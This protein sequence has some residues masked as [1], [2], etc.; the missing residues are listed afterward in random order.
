[1]SC[2]WQTLWLT[3]N[4]LILNVELGPTLHKHTFVIVILVLKQCLTKAISINTKGQYY[5]KLQTYFKNVPSKLE[6][7][8]LSGH[9]DNTYKD[10]TYTDFTCDNNKCNIIKWVTSNKS[11]L[12]LKIDLQNTQTLQINYLQKYLRDQDKRLW[13]G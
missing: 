5:K 9:Y 10:F 13:V 8:S 6:C 3:K 2:Q 7:L 1:V 12:L 4:I 11:S